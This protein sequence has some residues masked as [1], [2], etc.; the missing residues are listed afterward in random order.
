MS[1]DGCLV[2]SE[3][4]GGI[5]MPRRSRSK[6]L[7]RAIDRFKEELTAFI[8]SKAQ[9]RGDFMNI[10]SRRPLV[11]YTSALTKVG[12]QPDSRMSVQ[13]MRSPSHAE[14]LATR[15]QGSGTS[16]TPSIR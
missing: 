3:T 14:F 6:R 2:S 4:P 10:K 8:E 9:R 5:S 1:F 12:L 7:E 15:I 11:C 13:G 16:I